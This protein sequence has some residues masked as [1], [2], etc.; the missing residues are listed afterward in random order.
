[1][2]ATGSLAAQGSSERVAKPCESPLGAVRRPRAIATAPPIPEFAPVTGA[3][4]PVSS[5]GFDAA[6]FEAVVAI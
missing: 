6:D 1:V 3:F 4:R 5:R 2:R